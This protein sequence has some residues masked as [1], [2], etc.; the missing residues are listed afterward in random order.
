MHI[1]Y[2]GVRLT[3]QNCCLYEPIV[4][5]R[6]IAMWIME[7]WYRLGLTPNSS[8]R[9]L[10]QPPAVLS[11]EISLERV[12][13]W[14]KEMRIYSIRPRGTSRD[15]L[16]AVKSYDMGPCAL[17]PIREEGVLWIFIVLKNPSP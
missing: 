17:L 5:P 3:S 1:G 8:T 14:A 15:L 2:D 16:H 4:R 9:A 10:W 7:C 6:V 13:E 11:A 12:G